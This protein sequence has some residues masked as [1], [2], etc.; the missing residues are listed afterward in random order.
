MTTEYKFQESRIP[1]LYKDFRVL[2]NLNYDGFLANQKE[3]EKYLEKNCIKDKLVIEFNNQFLQT[4]KDESYGVAKSVD[5]AID[6]LVENGTLVPWD[7]YI[8]GGPDK[9]SLVSWFKILFIGTDTPTFSSRMNDS[10]ES[11]LKDVL[12]V[13]INNLRRSYEDVVNPKIEELLKNDDSIVYVREYFE[14]KLDFKHDDIECVMIYL[15]KYKKHIILSDEYVK[16]RRVNLENISVDDTANDSISIIEKDIAQLSFNIWKLEKQVNA[17]EHKLKLYYEKAK[18]ITLSR[19][20]RR[21]NLKNRYRLEEYIETLMN[22]LNKLEEIE[23]EIR[24]ALINKSFIDSLEY[25]K[26]VMEKVS[27][28]MKKIDEVEELIDAIREEKLKNE[29]ITIALGNVGDKIEEDSIDEELDQIEKEVKKEQIQNK[30][31]ETVDTEALKKLGT[32]KVTS[33]EPINPDVESETRND[34]AKEK[35]ATA[36]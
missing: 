15:E 10:K 9:S 29:Q 7:R 8:Q 26:T 13:C 17:N 30:N 35:K 2:K 34:M 28:E 6:N 14:S 12:F 20:V 25:S 18:D 4:I 1:S 32:L 23:N 22:H 16:L 3:W 33:E 27:K 5:V 36:I 24:K 11:Y 19:K 21:L 31:D